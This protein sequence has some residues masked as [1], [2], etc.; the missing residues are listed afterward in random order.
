MQ[1]G[2]GPA[3]ALWQDSRGLGRVDAVFSHGDPGLAAH[4]VEVGHVT[5]L[6][7]GVRKPTLGERLDKEALERLYVYEGLTA[8]Q[9]AQRYRS[10]KSNVLAL[11]ERYGI[12]PHPGE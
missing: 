6:H 5:A 11:L 2:A 4:T 10:F 8:E 9:I 12:P 1:L 7:S 3:E